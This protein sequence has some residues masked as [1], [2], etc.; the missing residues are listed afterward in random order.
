VVDPWGRCTSSRSTALKVAG[1][2]LLRRMRRAPRARSRP[3]R[4]RRRRSRRALRARAACPRYESRCRRACERTGS[5]AATTS[6]ESRPTRL[7]FWPCSL[8]IAPSP[9]IAARRPK[10]LLPMRSCS[11]RT[12]IRARLHAAPRPKPRCTL[13]TGIVA[14]RGSCGPQTRPGSGDLRRCALEARGPR[15]PAGGRARGS[16]RRSPGNAPAE[17]PHTKAALRTSA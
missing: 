13:G 15:S 1:R 2:A 3:L 6:S 17:Q 16:L 5:S 7:S 10:A 14:S 11:A 12:E 9:R 8:E 4:A